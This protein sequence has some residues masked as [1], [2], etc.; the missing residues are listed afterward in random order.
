MKQ[1]QKLRVDGKDV[2]LFP[3][4]Y[5]NITQGG[6]MGSHMGSNACDNAGKDAGIDPV[7]APCDM[8]YVAYYP[9]GNEV[10]FESDN[11]VWFRDGTL[12]YAVILFVHDN[13]ASDT[14]AKKTFK[15]GEKCYDEGTSGPATGNHLHVEVAKGKYTHMFD[16]NGY[17]V[18][19][20]P[21]SVPVDTAFCTDQTTIINKGPYTQWSDSSVLAGAH[22]THTEY[23]VA[24]QEPK[25][26]TTKTITDEDRIEAAKTVYDAVVKKLRNSRRTYKIIVKTS[27]LPANLEVGMKIRLQYD[28]KLYNLDNCGNYMRKILTLN[29]DFYITGLKRII[30]QYGDETG[31][32]ELE[33]F[34]KIERE[35]E[36]E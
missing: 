19:C 23:S 14:L 35:T 6:N 27:K 17:G 11:K 7:F 31:E 12:D 24:G 5:M 4:E 22:E 2:L 10:W 18:Y 26:Q 36:K 15:Q 33:K 28:N 1:G 16:V 8:H 3:M 29:N 9:V 30:G 20:L 21:R 34:L 32:L 13:D 25:D